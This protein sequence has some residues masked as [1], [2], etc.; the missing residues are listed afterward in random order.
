MKTS[1]LTGPWLDYFVAKAEH[2][3][4]KTVLPYAHDWT[5]GGP[6]IEE[7]RI[8]IG[9]CADD[10]V[11][12]QW[13]AQMEFEPRADGVRRAKVLFCE[14]PLIAAMR[15]YVVSKFGDEVPDA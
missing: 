4:T 11:G 15:A 6:I 13:F 12:K 7:Q 2:G 10:P 8:M 3:N 9:H 14:T 5:Y 1:E